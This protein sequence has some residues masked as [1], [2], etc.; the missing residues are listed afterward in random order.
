MVL[1]GRNNWG[2]KG[3]AGTVQIHWMMWR[4]DGND[5]VM[6]SQGSALCHRFLLQQCAARLEMC[7]KIEKI[8]PGV[9]SKSSFYEVLCSEGTLFV[10]A[11][12][13]RQQWFWSGRFYRFPERG[14]IPGQKSFSTSVF[15][16]KLCQKR[17]W[18][19]SVARLG[20]SG[21]LSWMGLL[22]Q[23]LIPKWT[24]VTAALPWMSGGG[25]AWGLSCSLLT[26]ELCRSY[27]RMR[28]L[29]TISSLSSLLLG[30][31]C[32]CLMG[33][34]G[35]PAVI[36]GW[37]EEQVPAALWVCLNAS[38]SPADREGVTAA[39][40]PEAWRLP[41]I[42]VSVGSCSWGLASLH[43]ECNPPV[44]GS[45]THLPGEHCAV[46]VQTGS[47]ISTAHRSLCSHLPGRHCTPPELSVQ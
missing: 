13:G 38:R 19:G 40:R 32:I 46:S 44:A 12:L 28:W 8:S 24:L 15:P 34:V 10:E 21:V 27:G 43:F 23:L 9:I 45:R 2:N 4:L 6:V 39:A 17:G 22:A 41:E 47:C 1:F 16:L 36:L 25:G 29:R 3:S 7:W 14:D 5:G 26:Q 30:G 42:Q 18:G 31:F 20:L 37:K 35:F 33:S 11:V